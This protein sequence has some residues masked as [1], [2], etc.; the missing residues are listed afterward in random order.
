[1]IQILE[2]NRKR[3]AGEN[4]GKA[5]SGLVEGFSQYQGQ[6]RQK[7]ELAKGNENLKRI[8]GQD[9]SGLPPDM[10]K[11]LA[12]ELVKG[13]GQGDQEKKNSQLDDQRAQTIGKFFGPEAAEIYKALPEGGKTQ[14]ASHLLENKQRNQGF[15]EKFEGLENELDAGNEQ[16]TSPMVNMDERPVS[17]KKT[18]DFDK[19]LTP[20]E[21][22]Q[23][24]NQR[25]EKNLPIYQES[26]HKHQAHLSDADNLA[27][28][29][30]LSPQITTMDKF[31]VNPMT[32]DI[33]IPQFASPEAQR[34]LKTINDFTKNAKD[35]YGARVTN[36]DIQQFLKRLPT[37]AN[38]EEGRRQLGRQLTI[39]NN[40]NLAREEE[41]QS[42]ID[43]HGGIR[44]IDFDE[45]ERI[46][47]K[48]SASKVAGLKKEFSSIG[49]SLDKSYG[50]ELSELKK[51]VPAGQVMVEFNDGSI[52]AIPKG[53]L[54]EF[55]N[56]QA[57]KV[58]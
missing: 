24:Q 10:Q 48:R 1:M 55:L 25:Y 40:I 54:Q 33:L 2:E 41:L 27:I 6:Q 4:M 3:T 51:L 8:T 57:G 56:D 23:R 22:A 38:S 5:L 45:A 37:L 12:Q 19:G 16:D 52:K 17:I 30:E 29:E 50:R 11:A 28:L 36:F 32:G 34:Y 46:A 58:L 35:S 43:E 39:M 21:R 18:K 47:D 15:G 49:N 44:N 42:V 31:N 7:E 13:I 14:F 53:N 26:Y 20:K 9:L